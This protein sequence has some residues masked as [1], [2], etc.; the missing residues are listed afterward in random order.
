V[1]LPPQEK[2]LLLTFLN[3]FFPPFFVADVYLDKSLKYFYFTLFTTLGTPQ[4]MGSTEVKEK[5]VRSSL[6]FFNSFQYMMVY[7]NDGRTLFIM[8]KQ[9]SNNRLDRFRN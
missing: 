1:P 6:F 8:H 5:K 3:N 4:G 7:E 2:E 9:P